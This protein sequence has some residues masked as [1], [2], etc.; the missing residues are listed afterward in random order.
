MGKNKNQVNVKFTDEQIKIISNL[1]G[2]MGGTDAEVVRNIF[3][4]W[5]SDK[6]ILSEILKKKIGN[7]K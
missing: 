6:S 3:L 7:K 4:A 5:L 2:I 1:I